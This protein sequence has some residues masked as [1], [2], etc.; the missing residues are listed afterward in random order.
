M[1][2]KH[3]INKGKL[4][5]LTF[6]FLVLGTMA[7]ESSRAQGLNGT[8]VNHFQKLE[9]SLMGGT[10]S[11][12][13]YWN[14]PGDPNF[15]LGGRFIYWLHPQIGLGA[16]LLFTQIPSHFYAYG[17][18]DVPQT[19]YHSETDTLWALEVT[20]V[21]KCY[22]I[23]PKTIPVYLLGGAGA[24]LEFT[25]NHIVFASR[26]P[27]DPSYDNFYSNPVSAAPFL[28]TGIGAELFLGNNWSLFGEAKADLVI[29]SG[30]AGFFC[31]LDA[32]ASFNL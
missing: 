21:S 5:S 1:I 10:Q 9:F 32:G 28:Q 7:T 23:N 20:A 12:L 22:P 3:W 29:G 8:P 30:T 24:M 16:S 17:S 6:G 13:N 25:T 2:R 14:N 31:P 26:D 15:N 19:Y 18:S 27:F 11:I 4:F